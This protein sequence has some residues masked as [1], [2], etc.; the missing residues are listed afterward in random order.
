ML[1]LNI[2][3]YLQGRNQAYYL[4]LINSLNVEQNSDFSILGPQLMKLRE[5]DEACRLYIQSGGNSDA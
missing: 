1:E 3:C 4:N 5:E 2:A